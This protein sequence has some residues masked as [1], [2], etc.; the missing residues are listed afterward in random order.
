MPNIQPYEALLHL[1]ADYSYAIRVDK[2][3]SFTYEW[4]HRSTTGFAA[5]TGFS[6]DDWNAS[7]WK[8]LFHPDDIPKMEARLERLFANQPS[9]DEYRIITSTGEERWVRDFGL[10]VWDEEQQRLV[11]IYGAIQDITTDKQALRESQE[12]YE[13]IG[14]HAPD[15]IYRFRIYP[16]PA[17][18]YVSP[19]STTV[20]G[21]TPEEHY[22]DPDLAMKIVCPEDFHLLS[23]IRKGVTPFNTPV[24]LRWIH[25]D[26][27]TVW[28]E[29]RFMPIAD[30]TG[31]VVAIEGI[32]RDITESKHAEEEIRLHASCAQAIA[33]ISGRLNGQIEMESILDI[34]T[35]ET[36]A[37][38]HTPIAAVCTY[39][40]KEDAFVIDKIY[41]LPLSLTKRLDPI[42]YQLIASLFRQHDGDTFIIQDTQDVS[43]RRTSPFQDIFLAANIGTLMLTMITRNQAILG[44]LIV[45]VVDEKR[46]FVEEE[47][48]LFEG[49]ANETAQ[50]MTSA[51]LFAD[52]EQKRALLAQRVVDRTFEL[53]EANAELAKALRTRDEFL[54]NMSHELRTPLNA[55]LGL[56][57]SLREEIY[58]TLNEKQHKR[59]STIETSGQQLLALINDVLDF[60]RIETGKVTLDP[61]QGSIE[62]ICQSSL[63]NVKHEAIKKNISVFFEMDDVLTTRPSTHRPFFDPNERAST[64]Y[65]DQ[66]RLKQILVGLL[67]NAIKFTAEGGEIGL[68]VHADPERDII[69]FVVWDTGPGISPA[70]QER[71]FQPFTQ[72]DSGLTKRFRGTG[73]GLALIR[74]LT[75]LHGGRVRVEST[76]GEGSRFI[77]TLPWHKPQGSPHPPGQ[78]TKHDAIVYRKGAL[79]GISGSPPSGTHPSHSSEHHQRLPPPPQPTAPP[80]SPLV[81]LVDDNEVTVEL[82]GEYLE[83]C[84][85]QVATAYN[86]A[87]ALEKATTTPPSLIIM[88]IQ[89]PGMNGLEAM[90]RIRH[91][92]TLSHIPIIVL[93]ASGMKGDR[94]KYI[95]AG[96]NEYLQK[97]VS[98]QKLIQTVHS[99]VQWRAIAR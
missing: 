93:T 94:E 86:G 62:I 77:I 85:Y 55:I 97:P 47:I 68:N 45:A 32:A 35:N 5:V 4:G 28:I 76:E 46:F 50:A 87:D 53:S 26:G 92:A 6:V 36:R 39:R 81:L 59:L 10:P 9:I 12:R 7:D 13:R 98:L 83:S 16:A 15:I 2:D 34:V 17:F 1:L 44:L 66:R 22:A 52:V 19:A 27:H 73:L 54:A 60:S 3:G 38:L 8:S 75:E 84:G 14:E 70:D 33:R 71:L 40:E 65:A 82:V 72:L 11:R 56:T 41:G 48:H 42:P 49:I 61:E 25:K 88:D 64:I 20:I 31:R 91:H 21:Y 90:Q 30:E 79:Q 43:T 96:A 58:G 37:A 69:S 24:I 99:V 89:M 67:S 29:Q 57:E 74:R 78:I 63:Q 95:H 51:R 80:G 23:Q 18:E